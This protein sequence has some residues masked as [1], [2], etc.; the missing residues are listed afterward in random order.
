MNEST[1]LPCTQRRP[2]ALSQALRAIAY[3][4]TV[5]PLAQ[6]CP[7]FTQDGLALCDDPH[8]LLR[9]AGRVED[10]ARA[11]ALAYRVYLGKGYARESEMGLWYGLHD[12]LPDTVTFLVDRRREA[13]SALTLVFDSPLGLPAD[14]LFA[15][16]IDALRAS[17]R[18]PCELV[19]LVSTETDRCRGSELVRQLF[20]LAHRAAE[21]DA[22]DFLITVNPRHAPFYIRKL[23]FER[24]G[25]DRAY[26]KVNGAPA[27]PLRLDLRTARE[28]YRAAYAGRP[29]GDDLYHFFCGAHERPMAAW[30]A[31]RRRPLEPYALQRYFE[32]LRPLLSEASEVHR[33]YLHAVYERHAMSGS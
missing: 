27:T 26:E 17:C 8:Y 23:L 4:D 31:A 15:Q 22:D 18:R 9:V 19:S 5:P 6:K 13:V 30:I 20:R 33:E 24:I 14:G 12:A 32:T 16:E 10:R 2:T 29:D 11:W 21:Q 28:R 25:P 7:D 1:A 3:P